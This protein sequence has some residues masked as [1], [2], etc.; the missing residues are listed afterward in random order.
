MSLND[1]ARKRDEAALAKLEDPS[2]VVRISDKKFKSTPTGSSAK[3]FHMPEVEVT[4]GDY[5]PGKRNPIH[6]ILTA[7]PVLMLLAGLYYFY[8]GESA[9]T[10]AAPI[11][12]ESVAVQGSFSGL[13]EIKSGSNGQHFLWLANATRKRGIR[14]QLS[15]VA[16][17]ADMERGLPMQIDM[18][19]TVSGSS[20]Y[21]A[22]R[23]TVNGELVLERETREN[24]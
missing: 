18:A 5:L 19:P 3:R 14:I 7:L 21:W 10:E 11:L 8:S 20:T 24:N 6:S 1:D 9:Q 16:I 22:W 13:S 12:A 4:P 2:A 15:E 17:F 23:V